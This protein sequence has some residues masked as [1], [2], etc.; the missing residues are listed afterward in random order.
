[1]SK[2][3]GEHAK[4]HGGG[5]M[6][7]SK[8]S[9]LQ[10]KGELWPDFHPLQGTEGVAGDLIYFQINAQVTSGTVTFRH[11]P[12]IDLVIFVVV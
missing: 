10:S 6:M 4:H 11:C 8:I 1:M 7:S 9:S 2:D 5:S 12:L 3:Y